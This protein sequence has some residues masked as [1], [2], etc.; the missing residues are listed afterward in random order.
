MKSVMYFIFVM[1]KQ[2]F[3]I[4]N[5]LVVN[6]KDSSI[7]QINRYYR[8]IDGQMNIYITDRWMDI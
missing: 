4:D 8:Q 3:G 6:F 1:K 5:Y 2:N 7:R